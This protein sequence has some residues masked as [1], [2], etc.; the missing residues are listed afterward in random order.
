MKLKDRVAFITGGGRGL[1]RAC[2]VAMAAEGADVIVVARS[3][4]QLAE[5]ARM[6]E[7]EGRRALA[8]TADLAYPEQIGRA[9]TEAIAAFGRVDVLVN[10]AGEVGPAALLHMAPPKGWGRTLAVNLTAPFLL[11]RG[12]VP[13]MVESGSGRIV[14]VTS[15]LGQIVMPVFGT[16]AV[17]KAGL[18]HLTRIMAEELR[19]S[20]V[21]VNALDPG[22]M[23][24]S[25]QEHIRSL[26]PKV[27]GP[28]L[29]EQFQSFKDLG[30]LRPPEEAARLAVWLASEDSEGISGEI[31]G[32]AEFRDYGYGL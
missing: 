19:G 20:G 9:V 13:S 15:G 10:N 27:L 5:T 17:S 31:G 26:G 2:A 30:H 18:N 16:Y 32:A 4:D 3:G 11:C 21:Q 25:M 12:L 1:G 22:V 8:V 24:T 7:S 14:N 23:D 28:P 29:F 6:V